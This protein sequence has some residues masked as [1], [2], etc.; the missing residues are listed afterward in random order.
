MM[1]INLLV[2]CGLLLRIYNN[3]IQQQTTIDSVLQDYAAMAGQNF[4]SDIKTNIG[5]GSMYLLSQSWASSDDPTDIIT[6]YMA[7]PNSELL[8]TQIRV[9]NA[10]TNIQ[11]INSKSMSSKV[12][13]HPQLNAKLSSIPDLDD[14]NNFGFKALHKNPAD[15]LSFSSLMVINPNYAVLVNYSN[16][17][18][19]EA[20]T[21]IIEKRA[22]LPSVLSPV[23][24]NH[25][26][27]FMMRN[28]ADQL[29][30][31]SQSEFGDDNRHVI[32]ID[33][34]YG[35]LF[36]GFTMTA[37]IDSSLAAS[38][39]IGGLPK[40]QIPQLLLMIGAALIA[41]LTTLWLQRKTHLLNQQKEQFIARASHELRT[42]LTQIRLFAETLELGRE[43]N[44]AK[45]QNYLN[46][47]HRESIRL[48]Q[49]VDNILHQQLI[50]Q[51]QIKTHTERVQIQKFLTD[52]IAEQKIL[53]QQKSIQVNFQSTD[54][55]MVNTDPN[56]LKQILINVLD[57]AVKFGPDQQIID[58]KT[59]THNSFITIKITDQGPG[60]PE[61]QINMLLQRY[62][63]LSRDEH[64]GINGNGLGLSITNHLLQE[65]D[66]QLHFEHPEIGLTVV[67][68][69]P[70]N[71]HIKK[72]STT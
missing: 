59:Y 40:S 70:I 14:V 68:K 49:L 63:R 32:T 22:M 61:S 18:V 52:L 4:V 72:G 45:Q 31:Q 38:L 65:L 29:L 2:L 10:I 35:S 54:D 51:S 19:T 58:I 57:N 28:Q 50:Q 71:M 56:L 6:S 27:R 53:W 55:L 15:D 23:K 25:N 16:D 46:I 69:L 9:R 17:F 64:R 13:E 37:A 36:E 12:I 66:G 24:N 42:P 39:I 47:I 30:W 7:R 44:L 41:M 48:S 8:P 11:I 5:Y 3:Q 67:I 20:L 1:A 33:D 60:I 62:T 21:F 43:K 26:I 34:D